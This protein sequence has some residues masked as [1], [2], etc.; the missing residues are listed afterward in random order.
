MGTTLD[1]DIFDEV[2]GVFDVF[3]GFDVRSCGSLLLDVF[4]Y[5]F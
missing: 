2:V 4:C 1:D 5:L 3:P